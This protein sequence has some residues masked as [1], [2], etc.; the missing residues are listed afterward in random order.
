MENFVYVRRDRYIERRSVIKKEISLNE[1]PTERLNCYDERGNFIYS[2]LENKTKSVE[3]E[4]IGFYSLWEEYDIL[5][6]LAGAGWEKHLDRYYVP[7]VEI[8]EYIFCGFRCVGITCPSYGELKE[9]YL[10]SEYAIHEIPY[11]GRR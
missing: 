2:A 8:W 4:I 1:C 9:D 10:K 3:V 6:K 5:G 7:N 11:E